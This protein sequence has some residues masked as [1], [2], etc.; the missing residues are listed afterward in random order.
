MPQMMRKCASAWLRAFF[1]CEGW[2]MSVQNK[3][4]SI[5]LESVNHY[6]LQQV[7]EC[8]SQKF[9]IKSSIRPKKNRETRILRICGKNNLILFRKHIG[10]L[11]PKKKQRLDEAIASFG[12]WRWQ[13]P[14]NHKGLKRFIL[15]ILREKV[16]FRQHDARIFSKKENL[17]ELQKK[18]K[19]VFGIETKLQSSRN[20]T[21]TL[22]YYLA[23]YGS[24]NLQRLRQLTGPPRPGIPSGRRGVV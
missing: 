11:H 10:F 12:S 17:K 13:F 19:S 21:G 1:D 6:G 18:L 22:Y 16:C 2:V 8:L 5:G 9:G 24:Q 20:G 7:H 15:E 3:D 4:R 14:D 23:F